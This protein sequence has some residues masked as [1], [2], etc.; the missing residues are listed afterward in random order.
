MTG[1]TAVICTLADERARHSDNASY[2]NVCIAGGERSAEKASEED[3]L[4]DAPLVTRRICAT[5]VRMV[6]FLPKPE[7]S[8][9]I[10]R[11]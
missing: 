5:P 8:N 3:V 7:Q 10:L 9:R 4:D 11:M 1:E 2:M 6:P